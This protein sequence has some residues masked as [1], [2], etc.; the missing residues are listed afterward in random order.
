MKNL[1]FLLLFISYSVFGQ[2]T[3]DV[4][5][6]KD[7]LV[8]TITTATKTG[9]YSYTYPD[10]SITRTVKP[11]KPPV[12]D[13][14]VI[15]PVIIPG[16]IEGFGKTNGGNGQPIFHVS[17]A[18]DLINNIKSNRYVLIDKGGTYVFRGNYTNLVNVTIDGSQADGPVI[19][20]NANNGGALIFETGC[21]DIIVKS[22][23]IRNAG[24]DNAAVNLGGYKITFDHCSLANGGD[25]NID[26]TNSHDITIQWCLIGNSVSGAS[27]IDYPGTNNVSIHHNI[28]SGFERNPLIGSQQKS[29]RTDLVCDF[30]N[31]IVWKWSNFGTD[32]NNGGT[33]N[34][35]NNYYYSISNPG[36]AVL[37]AANSYGNYPQGF[38]FVD[39]NFSGN[40]ID[41]NKQ[42]NHA[43]W[44]VP[45]EFQVTMQD[46]CTAARLVLA[47]AG[48][49]KKDAVDMAFINA[50]NL[51]GCP[52]Q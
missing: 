10:I 35:R 50:I 24:D 41:I 29:G 8:T 38:A 32:V 27:L 20:N 43:L 28:Y 42:S 19:I 48:P 16:S 36:R 44:P 4:L 3:R 26:I 17:N 45:V 21:H 6:N 15:P 12:I 46:A 23:A 34:V 52:A 14:V 5:L 40:G 22:I 30:T 9:T 31:N 13:T 2:T 47:S 18:T 11:Y 1:L 39:G 37:T 51:P 25:G 7:T 33:A 49:V